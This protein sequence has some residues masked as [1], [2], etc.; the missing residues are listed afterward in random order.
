MSKRRKDSDMVC[1]FC[2]FLIMLIVSWL[3]VQQ[4]IGRFA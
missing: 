2:A 3:M 1:V 4:L